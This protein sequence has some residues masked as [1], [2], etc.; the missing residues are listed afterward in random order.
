MEGEG[1]GQEGQ[2]RQV[3]TQRERGGARGAGEAS[4]HAEGEGRGK[5]GR[6]GKWAR[7]GR[8]GGA[9]GTATTGVRVALPPSRI[10]ENEA[11]QKIQ[12]FL[13]QWKRK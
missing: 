5:R 6:R 4:G 10:R 7:R 8:G 1:A 3:G 2:E 11:A 9:K 12:S 13:R